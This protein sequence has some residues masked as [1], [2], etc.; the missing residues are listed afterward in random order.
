MAKLAFSKLGLKL[1]N[2]VYDLVYQDQTI[3]VKAYLSIQDKLNII[4][5]AIKLENEYNLNTFVNIPMLEMFTH[6]EI[7]YAYT[8]LSFTEKQKEDFVKLYDLLNSNGVFAKLFDLI[9]DEYNY[10]MESTLN[11]AIKAYEYKNSV[12][13]ILNSLQ[14]DYSNLNLDAESIREKIADPENMDLL[15][16]VLAKLG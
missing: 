8:N 3:E 13:G 7:L 6:L 5:N 16:Q 10:I 4:E 15:K 11:T 12:Y 9:K 2:D 1:K 14:N